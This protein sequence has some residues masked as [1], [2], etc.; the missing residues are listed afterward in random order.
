APV[1]TAARRLV[2]TERQINRVGVRDHLIEPVEFFHRLGMARHEAVAEAGVPVQVVEPLLRFDARLLN[3][4]RCPMTKV[5]QRL[6][7]CG[8]V[9]SS[10]AMVAYPL[11]F[12]CG[13]HRGVYARLHVRGN[14]ALVHAYFPSVVE[15]EPVYGPKLPELP[16]RTS[17]TWALP[18]ALGTL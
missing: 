3:R 10:R 15:N 17:P 6:E 16:S 1:S 4:G 18:A 2:A 5:R 8:G 14:L 9:R 7:R 12:S 11:S 13:S